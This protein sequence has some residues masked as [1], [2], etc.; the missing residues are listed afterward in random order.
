M[1][2]VPIPLDVD[3]IT[4]EWL[5]AALGVAVDRVDVLDA[6]SGTT[7]RARLGIT[8]ADGAEPGPAS[9]F[10]KLAP[11]DPRQRKFVDMT[12]LG[13]AEARF[14]RDVADGVP[15]RVPIGHFSA[16]DNDGRFVMVLEDL[17]ASGCRFPGPGDADVDGV[18]AIVHRLADLHG[19]FWGDPRLEVDG[20]LDWVCDG[21]RVAF[22]H[23]GAYFARA[24][25]L[26][27]DEMGPTFRRLAELYVEQAPAIAQLLGAGP[28]TL[29]HGD[30]HFGNLFF[31]GDEAG[32]FDWGMVWR[33]TG[34]RDVA[35]V[36]GN[37][38]PVELRREHERMYL[39]HY[40]DVLGSHG[41]EL[42]FKKAWEQYRLLVIYAWSSATSTATMGSRWQSIEVGHAGM[43]RATAAVED[44]E[45]VPLLES[46]LAQI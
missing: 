22:E 42:K 29:I 18:G 1:D 40:V 6:H 21:N 32:F 39:R 38:T 46:M 31:D 13:V 19:R 33:A 41:A 35:Y 5:T 16:L 27:G 9:V 25:E 12:G 37:S 26:F 8:Y 20:A 24:L 30:P 17:V 3:Q 45:S 43:A 10:V 28:P 7:G 2:A 34:V 36:L 44:L 11:F 15:V 23:G 4:A 14:Y